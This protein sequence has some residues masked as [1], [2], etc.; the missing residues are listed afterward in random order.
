MEEHK[1]EYAKKDQKKFRDNFDKIEWTK[2]TGTEN[3]NAELSKQSIDIIAHN[4]VLSDRHIEDLA[5]IEKLEQENIKRTS[6]CRNCNIAQL[7][8]LQQLKEANEII[9][10][11]RHSDDSGFKARDYLEKYKGVD[12]SDLKSI[13]E[14]SYKYMQDENDSLISELTLCGK[15]NIEL[16]TKIEKLEQ[17][18]KEFKE[19]FKYE[20][21]KTEK[22][23]QQLKEAEK[24]LI[25]IDNWND[26]MATFNPGI[27]D[28]IK[29]YFKKYPKEI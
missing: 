10:Y 26:D 20:Y 1:I 7:N 19:G 11:Y 28:Y 29:E 21:E 6:D 13:G 4:K 23:I 16:K 8:Q 22:L 27:N 14:Y 9:Y 15:E 2:A 25:K 5:I 24:T 12:M 17:E 3:R 18:N